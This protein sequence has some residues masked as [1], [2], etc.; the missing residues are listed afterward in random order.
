MTKYSRHPEQPTSV[1]IRLVDGV[2]VKATTF[3]RAGM[4]VPQHAH[5]FAHLS[6]VAS[7]SARVFADGE[8]IGD[9]VAPAAIVIAARVKHLFEI[10]SDNT[11]V[12]CIH[13]ADRLEAGEADEPAIHAT[14]DLELED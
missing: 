8:S 2:F 7:G 12:L 9:F 1:D 14:H 13:N 5:V 6:Y 10:T 4:I 11:V 3:R